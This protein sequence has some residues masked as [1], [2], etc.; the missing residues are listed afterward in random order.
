MLQSAR[1]FLVIVIIG[2]SSFQ[3]QA[4]I[5]SEPELLISLFNNIY[6]FHFHDAEENL[7]SLLSENISPDLKDICIANYHWWLIVTQEENSFNKTEMIS[8]LDRIINR[9]LNIPPEELKPDEIF[10]ILHA[11]AYKS[12][13]DIHD[14]NYLK[15][16][17]NLNHA[18]KYLEIVMP[19]A[20]ENAKFMFLAGLYHYLAGTILEQHP[21]FHPLFLLAP[22]ADIDEGLKLLN[23]CYENEHPLISNEARYFIMKIRNQLNNE[24]LQADQIAKQLLEEFPDNQYY[25]SY[26]ISILADVDKLDE[27][28]TEYDRLSNLNHGEQISPAQ[29][30]FLLAETKKYLRKKRIKF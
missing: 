18:I 12:R 19:R 3:V 30:S 17:R 13:L 29:H 9:Y 22:K 7:N 14:N 5:D 4:Q 24:P 6:S 2:L 28:S 8:A 16:A 27:L 10:A 15:G 25:R 20:E 11:H 23:T 21:I 26:R 1:K